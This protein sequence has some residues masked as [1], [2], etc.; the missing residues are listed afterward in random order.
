MR[1]SPVVYADET[2]WW[3]NGPKHWLWVFTTPQATLYRIEQR[4]GKEVVSD[5]LGMDFAGVLV[6]DCLASYD[7]INCKKHKCYAHHLRAIAEARRRCPAS[8]YLQQLH[9]LLIAAMALGSLREEIPGFAARRQTLEDSADRLLN[10]PARGDPTEEHVA[11]RLRKQRAHLFQFLYTP[12]VEAT[13]NRAE[14]QLRPAVIARKVSCG[15][16]TERGKRT[17]EILMSL[18]ATAHLQ[19]KPFTQVVIPALSKAA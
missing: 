10:P 18:A 4:R 5:T 19:A 14:R 2:S 8:A 1:S 15:N 11:N 12:G 17:A 13:N 7:A 6:S 16:K 9:A 3:V